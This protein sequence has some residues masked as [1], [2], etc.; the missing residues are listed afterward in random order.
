MRIKIFSTGHAQGSNNNG[1]SDVCISV[2]MGP[3]DKKDSSKNEGVLIDTGFNGIYK[4][5]EEKKN[6]PEFKLPEYV[7]ITHMH[8]DHSTGLSS[9]FSEGFYPKLIVGPRGFSERTNFSNQGI[10]QCV[11]NSLKTYNHIFE[12]GKSPRIK[13]MQ[14]SE[15][16]IVKVTSYGIRKDDALFSPVEEDMLYNL[17]A[18]KNVYN[19]FDIKNME[20]FAITA[21]KHSTTKSYVLA[22]SVSE[23]NCLID[24]DKKI[25][26]YEEIRKLAS[27]GF[28]KN[29]LGIKTKK[30]L[31]E[32]IKNEME[33]KVSEARDAR[34]KIIE[35]RNKELL[36]ICEKIGFYITRN[37]MTYITDTP[38]I[39]E[40]YER[41]NSLAKGS[42]V[43]IC[44]VPDIKKNCTRIILH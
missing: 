22:Y 17:F 33:K 31:I 25:K 19:V 41:F 26:E 8:G 43:L 9:L 1:G 44:G 20:I 38:I 5:I 36:E 24:C 16:G 11:F 7:L 37:K 28:E 39:G 27:L 14:I 15:G 34:K 42:D 40:D 6:N 3:H 29:R 30:D 2:G 13:T 32:S 35:S 10:D 23:S 18:D 4:A 21:N 12:E